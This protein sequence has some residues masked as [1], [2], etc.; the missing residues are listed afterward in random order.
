M[1]ADMQQ[2]GAFCPLFRLHGH[3]HGGPP[4][5]ECGV[6]NGDNE[7]W[8]L[9]KDPEHYDAITAVM[10][11][12]ESLREYVKRLNDEAVA[13]GMPMMRP[14]TLQFPDD[15]ACSSTSNSTSFFVERQFMLGDEWLVSPVTE[16]N[17]TEWR[18][19]LPSA[20]ESAEWI[21]WWNQTSMPAGWHSMDV[22]AIGSFPLFV[23]RPI[24]ASSVNK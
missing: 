2:F 23:R 5:N 22:S 7:V 8:N 4:E 14:M 11:L 15:E 19:Y 20:G 6:T 12:R 3:R 17:A 21:Y 16:H 10:H 18:V 9:A 13:T 24:N 1:S